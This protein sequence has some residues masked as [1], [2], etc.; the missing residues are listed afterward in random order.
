[1]GLLDVHALADSAFVHVFP[2]DYLSGISD[3]EEVRQ[4]AERTQAKRARDI[5]RP[6]QAVARDE[7]VSEAFHLMHREGLSGLPIVDE[8][9]RVVGYVSVLE[10]LGGE[11]PAE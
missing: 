5:M 4:F 2:E 6:P 11:G 7:H 10:L 9:Y 8:R 1:V 3:L